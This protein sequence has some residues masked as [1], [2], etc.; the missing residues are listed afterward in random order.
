ME[1][2]LPPDFSAFLSSLNASGVEYLVVGGYAVGYHGYSRTT[3]DID[4]W[5]RQSPDNAERGVEAIRSF[6]FDTPNL[7][8]ER[9]L[10]DGQITRMGLP[11]NRIEVMT[12]LSGVSFDEAW[13]NRITSDWDGVLVPLI[14]LRRLRQ[15]KLASGRLKD[16]ADLDELPNPDE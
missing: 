15:N 16:L 14:D 3:G 1:T 13:A 2:R 8:R 9:F 6:G 7:I 10:G 12:S 5:I 4:V 11:P